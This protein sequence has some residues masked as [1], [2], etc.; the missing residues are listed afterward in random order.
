[1][2]RASAGAGRLWVMT[3][4]CW[5]TDRATLPATRPY[6][7]T[8]KASRML[9]KRTLLD[10]WIIEWLDYC[11][12]AD[13][14]SL[15][16]RPPTARRRFNRCHIHEWCCSSHRAIED[17]R[18]TISQENSRNRLI[19]VWTLLE[20]LKKSLFRMRGMVSFSFHNLWANLA[21]YCSRLPVSLTLGGGMNKC[22]PKIPHQRENA[23]KRKKIGTYAVEDDEKKAKDKPTKESEVD[24]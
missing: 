1:M 9:I 6:R 4:S 12:S 13:I 15:C 16:V 18:R 23:I 24:R 5:G 20:P 11:P 19:I 17:R 2:F 3:L 10:Q 8:L 14:E 21:Q 22:I 7:E